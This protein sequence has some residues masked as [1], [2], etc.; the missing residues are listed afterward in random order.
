MESNKK[1]NE[2]NNESYLDKRVNPDDIQNIGVLDEVENK[3][4]EEVVNPSQKDAETKPAENISDDK[5]E[6]EQRIMPSRIGRKK[7]R[8]FMMPLVLGVIAIII[9]GAFAVIYLMP[10]M[11]VSQREESPQQIIKSAMQEMQ[12]VK[13]YNYDGIMEFNV[14]DRK[15]F[16]NFNF[17][18]DLSG[19]TD[20]TDINNM[21]S[22][23]NL[24]ATVDIS[25]EGS[26]QEFSFDLDTIQSGQKKAYLKLN[27]LDLGTIG[28]MMGPEINSLVD[29]FKGN[30][31]KLDVEEL[32][33]LSAASSGDAGSMSMATYDVN[34]IME[35]YNKY[36]LLKFEED[37]GDTKIGP[38]ETITWALPESP[39]GGH[40][41]G[42]DIDAYHYKVK[43]D[44]IALINF[45]VDIVK[46]MIAEMDLEYK[47]GMPNEEFNETF[48]EIVKNIKKYDYVINKITDNVDVEIWIGKDDK[49]IYRTK[50]YGEFDKEFIETL[51]NEMI[52]KGDLLEEDFA[53]KLNKNEDASIAFYADIRMSDFNQP[54][55]INEPEEA[56]NLIEIMEK[57][58]GGF[59]KD[60]MLR[61]N[62]SLDSDNDGLPDYIENLY[63]VDP[64]NPDTDGDGYT[65]GEEV[66]N[67]FD[68]LVPGNAKLDYDK[69]FKG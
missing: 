36:E 32:E 44:G 25:T 38:I 68:P 3:K 17:D 6:D 69:L 26:S 47:N 40:K 31:Y 46:E 2:Y 16:E 9:I 50:I 21:K 59:M 37:L 5:T 12:K 14:E 65:D 20:Q 11:H 35:L 51:G 28:I 24:K 29:S 57:A 56:E 10:L 34:K 19:K 43:L 1:N 39:T 49:L 13:T 66:E 61:N 30:W 62:D 58:V 22:F 7:S 4:R 52:A 60:I 23:N 8:N 54:V 42:E 53:D 33:K 48:E 15:N 41:E 27:N 18:I 63:G 45:Y 67:G 55:E 64:N